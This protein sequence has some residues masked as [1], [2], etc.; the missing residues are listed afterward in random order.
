MSALQPQEVM[1][2][3]AGYFL[4]PLGTFCSFSVKSVESELKSCLSSCAVLVLELGNLSLS[5][6]P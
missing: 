2:V 4:Q 3:A 6:S 1:V 5:M